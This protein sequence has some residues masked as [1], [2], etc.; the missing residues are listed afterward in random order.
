MT[1]KMGARIWAGTIRIT[2]KKIKNARIKHA[3]A[4][5]CLRFINRGLYH[6]LSLAKLIWVSIQ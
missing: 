1:M 2:P 3:K 5:T 4:A 6:N